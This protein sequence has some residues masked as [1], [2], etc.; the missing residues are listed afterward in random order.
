MNKFKVGFKT[1]LELYTPH[2]TY[3]SK[4]FT[5]ILGSCVNKLVS[6]LQNI[7]HI[8]KNVLFIDFNTNFNYLPITN[9]TLFSRSSKYFNKFLKYFD[10]S[11]IFF[12][13]LSKKKFI[14]KKLF[15]NKVVNISIDKNTFSTKFDLNLN[16]NRSN[17]TSYVLYL[18][19]MNVYLISKK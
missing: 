8:N 11:V 7:F 13:N 9:N 5:F 4:L 19:V 6:L 12:F 3:I 15:S 17:L 18:L 14:F 1:K 16:L 2:T 10:V